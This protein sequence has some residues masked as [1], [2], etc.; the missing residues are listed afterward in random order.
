MA[1]NFVLF[2]MWLCY[3]ISVE[4]K[5]L[6]NKFMSFFSSISL[7]LY[8][9][10]MVIY[11][12]VEKAGLLYIFG[13]GWVSFLV[14]WVL[15]VIGLIVFIKIYKIGIANVFKFMNARLLNR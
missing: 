4:S 3:G 1:K 10:Q 11:R 12:L 6:N 15:I 2:S 13:N 8:L 5:V 7:E 14:M 9:A